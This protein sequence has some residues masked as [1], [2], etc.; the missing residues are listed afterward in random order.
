MVFWVFVFCLFVCFFLRKGKHHYHVQPK[1]GPSSL[2]Q[3]DAVTTDDINNNDDGGDDNDDYD[4][5]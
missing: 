1:H 4:D 3:A 5:D 2:E